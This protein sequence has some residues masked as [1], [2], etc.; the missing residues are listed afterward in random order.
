MVDMVA[1]I[2]EWL[3]GM[4]AWGYEAASIKASELSDISG[5]VG[6]AVWLILLVGV[7]ILATDHG[8]KRGLVLRLAEG[9]FQEKGLVGPE[10]IESGTEFRLKCVASAAFR[11]S[12]KVIK[13][14]VFALGGAGLLWLIHRLLS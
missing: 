7:V 4:A 5:I 12:V 1:S 11:F 6:N 3:T 13:P 10:G 14:L 9:F 8:R 2:R